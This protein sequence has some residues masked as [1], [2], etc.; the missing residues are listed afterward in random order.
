MSF[1]P[2]I[3][4]C[5]TLLVAGLIFLLPCCRICSLISCAAVVFRLSPPKLRQ[6]EDSLSCQANNSAAGSGAWNPV[7]SAH[8]P[9]E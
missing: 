6:T 4:M 2:P 7:P 5:Y 9:Q 1:V 3:S 8:C